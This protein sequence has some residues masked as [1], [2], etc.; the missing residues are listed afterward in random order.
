MAPSIKAARCSFCGVRSRSC[1]LPHLPQRHSEQEPKP[2]SELTG[3][4]QT[5]N[6]PA[7][8]IGPEQHN[9]PLPEGRTR[10]WDPNYKRYFFISPPGL[11]RQFDAHLSLQLR[12]FPRL[13]LLALL[14]WDYPL[15]EVQPFK[16][17]G[18][19][20]DSVSE[21]VESSPS[22]SSSKSDIKRAMHTEKRAHR[23]EK[24]EERHAET[25][26]SVLENKKREIEKVQQ[27]AARKC[28]ATPRVYQ[29]SV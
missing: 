9:R 21:S 22:S 8:S 26:R 10:Q 19:P 6:D 1:I 23:H 3:A 17:R 16:T 28:S 24:R 4:N 18:L 13:T 7:Q 15:N 14:T 2:P 11:N 12:L 27:K 5:S 20:A 25:R 29:H